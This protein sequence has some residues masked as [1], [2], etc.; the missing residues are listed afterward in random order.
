MIKARRPLGP[1]FTAWKKEGTAEM[2]IWQFSRDSLLSMKIYKLTGAVLHAYN[3]SDLIALQPRE[4]WLVYL[5]TGAAVGLVHGRPYSAG[6]LQPQ[7]WLSCHLECHLQGCNQWFRP[8][9]K[10]T[11]FPV[12]LQPFCHSLHRLWFGLCTYPRPQATVIFTRSLWCILWTVV[13]FSLEN[14]NVASSRAI[15][16]GEKWVPSLNV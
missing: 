5:N 2:V 9:G 8:M 13:T 1:S 14:R 15:W 11:R 3:L 4:A 6:N 12:L 16:S 7:T 10:C